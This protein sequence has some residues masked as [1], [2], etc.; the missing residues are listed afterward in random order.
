MLKRVQRA[1]YSSGEKLFSMNTIFPLGG[2]GQIN[3]KGIIKKNMCTM[4]MLM[5]HKLVH[6]KSIGFIENGPLTLQNMV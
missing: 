1:C 6:R 5:I 4:I 3:H 2:K